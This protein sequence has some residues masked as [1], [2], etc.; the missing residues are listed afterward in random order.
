MK[1]L[2]AKVGKIIRTRKQ[3]VID[4][5]RAAVTGSNFWR[6]G[7]I[8]AASFVEQSECGD[9]LLFRGSGGRC[10]LIRSVTAGKYDHVALLLRNQQDNVM[11]LE[12]TGSDGVSLIPWKNFVGWGWHKCYERLAFRKVYFDRDSVQ[13]E[14]L[15]QY[16]YSIL[17]AHYSLTYDKIFKKKNSFSFDEKGRENT[18]ESIRPSTGAHDRASGSFYGDVAPGPE[19]FF[20]SEVVA[21]CL[22][23]CGVLAGARASATYWPSS[24][25]QYDMESLPLHEGV[26][27]GAEQVILFD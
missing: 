27:I 23:R 15:Q 12:A 7:Y 6:Y 10:Q 1:V 5:E 8:S 11:V 20:C 14:K 2:A 17:G 24:F 9:I 21:A 3:I 18:P 26:S 4:Q 16:V 19:N 22:K 25:S 13:M